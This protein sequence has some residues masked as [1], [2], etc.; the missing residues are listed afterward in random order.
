MAWLGLWLGTSSVSAQSLPSASVVSASASATRVQFSSSIN[1]GSS[2]A[3]VVFDYGPTTSY[4]SSV[5][6]PFQ[7]GMNVTGQ[8]VT[9]IATGLLPGTTYHVSCAVT[10]AT[11]TTH[12]PDATFTT[13]PA[14]VITTLAATNVTDLTAVLNGTV[15]PSGGSYSVM[16]QYGTTTAYGQFASG[17]PIQGNTT[18]AVTA[19]P[20]YLLPNTTYHYRMGVSNAAGESFYADDMTFTTAAAATPPTVG[21]ARGLVSSSRA[22]QA[23]LYV[24]SLS[25]GSSVTTVSYQYGLTTAYG[26][27]A[28]YPATYPT[29]TVYTY[30]GFN[31]TVLLSGLVP[32][33]TYHFRAKAANAQ[34]VVYSPDSTFTLPDG[35]VL[36]TTAPTFVTDLTAQMNAT[37][38]SSG[39]P[40]NVIFEI[41]TTTAYGQTQYVSN[42]VQSTSAVPVYAYPAG[43]L[44]ATTYHYRVKAFN[45]Y[46]AT[47]F[48]VGPD[49]IF[50]TA[51]PTTPPIAFFS[52]ASGVRT[53]TAKID[54]VA[55]LAG[56][57]PASVVVE[58]GTTI[59]YG[60]GVASDT[61]VPTGQSLPV[62]VVLNNLSPGTTYHARVVATNAQ[63]SFA[64]EDIVFT[65]MSLVA[66]SVG[67]IFPLQVRATSAVL[68]ASSVDA[69]SADAF[70]L[71]QAGLTPAYG[72]NMAGT[73]SSVLADSTDFSLVTFFGLQPSTTYHYRC[74]ASS[75]DGTS[76]SLDD[77]F[78]TAA[79]PVPVTAPAVGVTDLWAILKGS[80]VA[81]SGSLTAFFELG[82]TTSYGTIV[83]PS[84][85]MINSPT[86]TP[87]EA[88]ASGLL[89]ST[90]YHYRMA[91]TDE[92][93]ATYYGSD[94]TFTTGAPATPPT[95][96]VAAPTLVAAQGATLKGY[97]QSG[98]S[99][100]TIVFQYGTTTAYGSQ[101]THSPV[102]GTS[103]YDVIMEP[104]PGLTP[105]TEYHYRVV[106]T[107]AQG[108]VTSA[109]M[110]FTT[111]EL[112]VVTTGSASNIGPVTAML[113]GTCDQRGGTGYTLVLEYG[114]T[115]AY[116]LTAIPA[117][118]I[119]LGGIILIGGV[120]GVLSPA[121]TA[122]VLPERTYHF[123]L[124]AMDGYGNTYAGAD[125]TFTT[126]S[127][128][129]TWRQQYFG[130]A[131]NTGLGA[132][133][134]C[135][136]G[137]GIVN[138]M[139]YALG[140]DPNVR[141]TQ[142]ATNTMTI[143][144][145]RY[146]TI[147]FSRNPSALDLTYEVQ[148]ASD[149]AGPWTVVA[150]ILPGNLQCTGP[151]LVS[152]NIMRVGSP[153]GGYQAVVGDTVTVRDTI[154]TSDAT[155]RFLRLSVHR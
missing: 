99:P 52:S 124:I 114:E 55:V 77:S 19:N 139:K 131:D 128:I 98:S 49:V 22:T 70:V 72:M 26:Q 38:N 115:T 76:S 59:A 69:G 132:D 125:A 54:C 3:T 63:G 96:D 83:N 73:P 89:P 67:M 44:P 47:E 8:Y 35:P 146:L 101:I 86:S 130:S 136:S 17:D 74:T 51:A 105:S 41:G 153:L 141:G 40:L 53:R 148:A 135:P 123:R 48:F 107:N 46:D 33:A 149:L 4:G 30:G 140:L 144:N 62:S 45:A 116:G 122:E 88:L 117:P 119:N 32:G 112:P 37:V 31:S 18:L 12:C 91:V 10:N 94:R 106:A 87:I 42:V 85:P 109:D 142:P 71:W 29:N 36:T 103:Q 24:E 60:S 23:Q 120:G 121:G 80:G 27:E 90:T 13:L 138:L 64:T 78:T 28:V 6:L 127:G 39:L 66:P 84:F 143:G 75:A 152:E 126:P 151:G 21:P 1:A 50:T 20:F 79:A 16:A 147:T 108:T 155:R 150:S 15:N 9:T 100:A 93:G 104:L 111:K 11:G 145:Q 7:V 113:A 2:D 43:L 5:V 82:T 137:D 134:A 56:S 81:E 92:D 95:A 68:Q 118:V 25:T 14:P 129:G 154:G 133:D 34:G 110:T 97:V 102:L 65:T 58:Y 61:V 57:S